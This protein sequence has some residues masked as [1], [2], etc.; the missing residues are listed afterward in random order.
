MQHLLQ[1]AM[2][3]NGVHKR[4]AKL[5]EGKNTMKNLEDAK[6]LTSGVLVSNGKHALDKTVYNIVKR[7]EEAKAAEISHKKRKRQHEFGQH[8]I[9]IA[10]IRLVRGGKGQENGFILWTKTDMQTYL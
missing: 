4:R 10:K 1:E 9:T 8:I 6:R 3:N 7:N 2:Q 5:Y